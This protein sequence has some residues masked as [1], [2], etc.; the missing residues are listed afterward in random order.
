MG[1]MLIM[2]T[3]TVPANFLSNPG[4]AI[5][6][7]CDYISTGTLATGVI[8]VYWGGVNISSTAALAAITSATEWDVYAR[9]RYYANPTMARVFNWANSSA[10]SGSSSEFLGTFMGNQSVSNNIMNFDPT[11]AQ[12][13]YCG[14]RVASGVGANLNFIGMMISKSCQ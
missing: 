14:A 3:Y 4:E 6:I 8:A 9:I 7:E 5:N 11:Q 2:S 1:G 13:F 12:T 10:G